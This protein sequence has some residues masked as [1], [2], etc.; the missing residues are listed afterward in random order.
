MKTLFN[1]LLSLIISPVIAQVQLAYE[2]FPDDPALDNVSVEKNMTG[3]AV[4]LQN[5]GVGAYL[6]NEA[7]LSDQFTFKVEFSYELYFVGDYN[8]FI[9]AGL[10]PRWYYNLKMRKRKGKRVS[11]NSGPFVGIR[12]TPKYAKY[13]EEKTSSWSSTRIE[14]NS[15]LFVGF[16]PEWGFKKALGKKALFEFFSGIGYGMAFGYYDEYDTEFQHQA[17][18]E[19][20]FRLGL[21]Y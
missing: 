7:K 1:L 5:N 18:G 8:R 19:F 11:G 3:V 17:Y 14:P 21:Q 20:G 4:G 13:L 2:P 15:I 9:G 12:F 6:F 16:L 10:E